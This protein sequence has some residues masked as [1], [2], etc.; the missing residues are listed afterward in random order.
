MNIEIANRLVEL[1]KKAGLS[2][3]ELADKIGL[4][5][6]AVSKWER[7]EA[8]PDTDNLICLAKI[9]GVSLDDLLNTDEPIDEI[10]RNV[11]EKEEAKKEE[12]KQEEPQP[13]EKAEEPKQE[14]PKQE[15]KASNKKDGIHIESKD[16]KSY[17]HIGGGRVHI[18]DDDDEVVIESG[19][20]G[21]HVNAH[22]GGDGGTVVLD[23]EEFG[24]KVENKMN[25]EK[26][27][28]LFAI[29]SSGTMVLLGVIAY[30]IAGFLWKEGDLGWTMCWTF[31]L[32]GLWIASIAE[33][34][35]RR[36]FCH[37]IY[38]L[39]VTSLYCK[40]GFLGAHYGFEGW[41]FYWWLF[42]TIPVFYIIFGKI[43]SAIHHDKKCCC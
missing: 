40:L 21:I 13:E 31:I 34:I 41:G 15:E 28:V 37:F 27:N 11:K 20:D 2:Q 39:F 38:P 1:R 24:K 8:S 17:V 12:A 10:A 7:A 33:C 23:G 9:Y 25:K 42:I 29:F 22:D 4:S 32:D 16:G 35:H 43:D 3:E 5:R 26:E 19:P 6:Q 36:R 14:E 30:I 18:K